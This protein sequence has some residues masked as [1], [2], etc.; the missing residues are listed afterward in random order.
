MKIKEFI[1]LLLIILSS[2]CADDFLEKSPLDRLSSSNA[3]ATPDEME[4]YINQFY[5]TAFVE[6]PTGM[7]GAGI[8]FDDRIGDNIMATPLVPRIAGTSSLSSAQTLTQYTRIRATN[9]FFENMYNCEGD[10]TRINNLTGEAYFF[11]AMYYF[12][13]VKDY[14]DVTWVNE[15]LPPV[16]EIM[17]VPRD[18]RVLVVDS[19]LADLNKAIELL[20]VCY[21]SA[22]M[23][24][25]KDVA[26]A[27]KS[28]VA[29]FEGTWQKYHKAKNDKF[30]TQGITDDKIINYL[31][32]ARDAAKE[33]IDSKRWS[34]YSTGKPF[35]DYKNMFITLDL[36]N[37]PEI[38]LWKKYDSDDGIGNSITRYLNGGGGDM[39]ITLSLVDDYLTIDGRIFSGTE[40]ETAQATYGAELSPTLRD[41]R[42]SQTVAM[43]GTRLKPLNESNPFLPEYP[44]I[45]LSSW[46][47][48]TTGFPLLKFVEMDNSKAVSRE[49]SAEAPAI[50]FRYAE[51]L[52]NYAEALA[53]LGGDPAEISNALNLLRSRVDMPEVDFVREYNTDPLYPFNYLDKV[54]QA[55]R[56]ERR[57]ELACEG[58]RMDDIMRWAAAGDLLVNKRPLGALFVG[59]DMEKA[60]EPG[61]F[62]A[63]NGGRLIYSDNLFL[64]GSEGDTKRYIDPYRMVL[65]NGFGFREDRDYL[66]PIQER[67]L[68]LTGHKWVQNPGW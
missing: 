38:M 65:P 58:K 10:Q 37:N 67:Q 28:W 7:L 32:Q 56:R 5:N 47:K 45:N 59:S 31:E 51:V 3:L 62:Y 14:G 29:L 23:R 63:N 8:A 55:V 22:T 41:P 52:L 33:V 4:K 27:F 12:L 21:N 49:R 64:T 20:P 66:L 57:I 42:L 25:H 35:E 40:R 11:R 68:A 6:Q 53:E 43:P 34:I 9:F 13:L 44:P 15:V 30:F 60:N 39:G 54:L 50:Q 16:Q 19:I 24:V 17:E 18:S 48:N 1:I 36:S 46:N 61:G 26:L 2:G